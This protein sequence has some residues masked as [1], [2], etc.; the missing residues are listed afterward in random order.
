[1]LLAGKVQ[2]IMILP[3]PDCNHYLQTRPSGG[4][5]WKGPV[6]ACNKRKNKRGI[7]AG[8]RK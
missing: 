2:F 7:G 6:Y 3:Y 5:D 4:I 1:M 8:A